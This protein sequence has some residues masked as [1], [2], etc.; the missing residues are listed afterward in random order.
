MNFPLMFIMKIFR[1]VINCQEIDSFLFVICRH[2][3]LFTVNRTNEVM[4]D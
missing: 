4:V 2:G 1:I 3:D